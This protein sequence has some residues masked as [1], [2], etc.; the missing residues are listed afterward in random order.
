MAW[1]NAFDIGECEIWLVDGSG[2]PISDPASVGVTVSVA[3]GVVTADGLV[4]GYSVVVV[5]FYDTNQRPV[6]VRDVTE[7]DVEAFSAEIY[8]PNQP[9]HPVMSQEIP[10][11]NGEPNPAEFNNPGDWVFS[12]VA[13]RGLA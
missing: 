7:V 11:V 2:F 8:A 5:P 9:S 13:V 1:R 3:G 4:S 10:L 6:R 12:G